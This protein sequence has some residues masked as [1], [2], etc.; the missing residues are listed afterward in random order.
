MEKAN[1]SKKAQIFLCAVLAAVVVFVGAVCV[2]ISARNKKITAEANAKQQ[3]QNTSETQLPG[4]AD[5]PV[6]NNEKSDKKSE[7]KNSET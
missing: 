2:F 4:T 3:T 5:A 7:A 6:K 1:N